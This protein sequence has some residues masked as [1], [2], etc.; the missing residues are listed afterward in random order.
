MTEISGEGARTVATAKAEARTYERSN[1]GAGGRFARLRL[2]RGAIPLATLIA[3]VTVAWEHTYHAVTLGLDAS[4]ADH[5]L[6]I[7]RDGVLVW[8]LALVA[9]LAGLRFTGSAARA[10]GASVVMGLLLVPS[11]EVHGRIDGALDGGLEGAHHHEEA[12]SGLLGMLEH[13]LH[14]ALLA[15]VALIPLMFLA[16]ALLAGRGRH[17]VNARRLR[18]RILLAPVCL[19]LLGVLLGGLGLTRETSVPA[20]GASNVKMIDL[21]DNPG[22][23]FDTGQSIAGTRSLAVVQSGTTV[24]FNVAKPAAMTVHTASSLLFPTGASSM[25]FDQ[26][27]AFQGTEDVTLTDPGLY[28]FVCKLHPFM[29]GGIIVDDPATPELDLGKTL[30]MM[31]GATVPSASDLSLRLVRAFFN[32]TSPGNYQVH[33]AAHPTTWDPVYPAVP[34]RAYDKDSKPVVIPNLDDFLGSYFH[35]PVTLPKVT[36]PSV[37][38]VG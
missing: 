23:W 35:E 22:N 13:G 20:A 31:N 33:S 25:P 27:K 18:T 5:V 11:V 30:T 6:H 36:A 28:V 12:A 4:L 3:L 14:D 16:F 7:L 2:R 1:S 8:P 10:A 19:V 26:D 38:G 9:A 29:L 21:T 32:I 34:V 37:K 15:Q 24:R 17:A